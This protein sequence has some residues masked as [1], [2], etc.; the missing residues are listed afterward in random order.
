MVSGSPLYM[1]PEQVR[2]TKSVDTRT[3]VWAL[4]VILYELVA[5]LPPF[6]ADTVTGLC[7][8]IVADPPVPLRSRR[9]DISPVLE[10][11]VAR[12]LD[13]SASSTAAF[14]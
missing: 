8:K 9:A 4:G 10:A 13:K 2:S 1:S 3:D 12:C 6:E 7:A 14:G 11:I 5:G